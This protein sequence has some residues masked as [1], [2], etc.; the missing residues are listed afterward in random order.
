MYS[1]YISINIYIQAVAFQDKDQLMEACSIFQKI[2][3][4]RESVLG[5]EHPKTLTSS[6]NVGIVYQ[7]LG[8]LDLA[9]TLLMKTLNGY[10]KV[11]NCD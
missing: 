9:E 11:R 2:L 6:W 1:S 8:Q 7:D 4:H 10:T 5:S 3:K